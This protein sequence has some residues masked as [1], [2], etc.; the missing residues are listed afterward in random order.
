MVSSLL[1][2]YLFV[3]PRPGTWVRRS[4]FKKVASRSSSSAVRVLLVVMSEYNNNEEEEE[5]SLT[6]SQQLSIAVSMCLMH[7]S[8]S[9][10]CL[11]SSSSGGGRDT[12]NLL[13]TSAIRLYTPGRQTHLGRTAVTN[14][15]TI[16]CLSKVSCGTTTAA[17]TTTTTTGDDDDDEKP[18]TEFDCCVG[19]STEQFVIMIDFVFCGKCMIMR[20]GV[21]VVVLLFALVWILRVSNV[22]KFLF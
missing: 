1:R 13:A 11:L 19:G 21:V 6:L 7:L 5:S 9:S 3:V 10:T 14:T 22:S 2:M 16:S 20:L 17:T 8:C 12:S 4:R 18:E 15:A